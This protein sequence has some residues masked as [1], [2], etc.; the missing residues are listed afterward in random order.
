MHT[1]YIAM[2]ANVASPAGPPQATL[3][4]AVERLGSFGSVLRRSSLYS[5]QPVGFADQPRF[6]N[7]VV[8]LETT[9]SP[10]D[11]LGVLLGLEHE[12][13]RDRS[14]G[15][16]NGPRT[17]DLDILLY[18]DLILDEPARPH[19]QIPHPRLAERAFVLVPLAEIAPD[20]LDPR[21]GET[22][23]TLLRQLRANSPEAPKQV[24]RLEDEA[25][26]PG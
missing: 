19:L 21:S 23:A 16:A 13:G 8:S 4:A 18:D 22:I 25:W 17:L 5:T 12:F 10:L 11:L 24:D 3:A 6:V 2:G 15:L 26:I 20:I 7:A 1:S 9:L 14:A